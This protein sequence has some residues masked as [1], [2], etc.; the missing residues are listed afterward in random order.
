VVCFIPIVVMTWLINKYVERTIGYGYDKRRQDRADQKAGKTAGGGVLRAAP[1]A[2]RPSS[3][4]PGGA[5]T[6]G[7]IRTDG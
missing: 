4:I 2:A 5:Q 3:T 6:V 7:L 1:V